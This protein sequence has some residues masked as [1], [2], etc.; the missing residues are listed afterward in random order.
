MIIGINSITELYEYFYR[1]KYNSP[2]YRFKPTAQAVIRI[3]KLLTSLH[4]EY[5]LNTLG[6]VFLTNYFIFQF[7]RTHHQVFQRFASRDNQGGIKVGGRIQIYDIVSKQAFEYW[8]KRDVNFDWL[9]SSCDFVKEY[10]I[11]LLDCYY[12]LQGQES[13]LRKQI[14]LSQAEEI[15]K[16]RFFN[17]DR[18]L[19]NCLEKTSLYNRKSQNCILCKNRTDCKKLLQSNYPQ[20]YQERT[21]L[22][23]V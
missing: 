19:I 2:K 7:N 15:E 5:D 4:K 20:I 18:G 3:H 9:L 14:L 11:S 23:K 1:K 21:E 12:I 16:K 22:V 17:T 10:N 13:L 6:K 8:V